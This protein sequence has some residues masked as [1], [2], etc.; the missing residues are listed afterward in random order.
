MAQRQQENR[1]NFD[2]EYYYKFNQNH[3]FGNES[4]L[5]EDDDIL[6]NQDH[7]YAEQDFDQL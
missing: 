7:I 2:N 6:Y 3:Y 1:L 4:Y 5:N